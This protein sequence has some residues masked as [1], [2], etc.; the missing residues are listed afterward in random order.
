MRNQT[1]NL[2]CKMYQCK[3]KDVFLNL[4]FFSKNT[5]FVKKCV[6]H[7]STSVN[8]SDNKCYGIDPVEREDCGHSGIQREECENDRGCCFDHTVPNVPWCFKGTEPPAKPANDHS[9][10]G[11]VFVGD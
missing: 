10:L 11:K 9:T 3:K 4:F 6:V 8:F 2:S 7:I 5:I 1:E